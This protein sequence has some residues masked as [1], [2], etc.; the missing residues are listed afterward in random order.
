MKLLPLM[1][2]A[3]EPCPCGSGKMHKKCCGGTVWVDAEILFKA[4]R[5]TPGTIS[6]MADALDEEINKRKNLS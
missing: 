1:Y 2:P 4:E 6:A 3:K 5:R